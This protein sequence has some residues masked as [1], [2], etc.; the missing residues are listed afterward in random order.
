MSNK[1]YKDTLHLMTTSFSI[2]SQAQEKEPAFE[3]VWSDDSFL[4][5]YFTPPAKASF[6]LHDGPPYANGDIHIGHALNKI[7]KDIIIRIKRMAGHSVSFI[8]GWDCHGLPIE[9][10]VLKE[11]E[12]GNDVSTSKLCKVSRTYAQQWVEK[13]KKDFKR[14]GVIAE[15]NQPYVTMDPSYQSAIMESFARLVERGFITRQKKTVPWCFSCQTVLANAEIEYKERK[16][17]SCYILFPLADTQERS[18]LP[19]EILPYELSFLIWTTTPWTIPLNRAVVIHPTASYSILKLDEKRACIVGADLVDNLVKIL[20]IEKE[21]LATVPST[22][23]QSVSLQHPLIDEL[24]VPIV[25]DHG[26]GLTEGT[27]CVHSAPGCGP[28][29]YIIGIK[30]KLEIYSPLTPQGTY[31]PDIRPLHLDGLPI[32]EGQWAVLKMLKERNYLLHKT[33][34]MHSYPHCWRCHSGLM[35]RATEQWF[36]NVTHR[37]LTK[38]AR[39]SLENIQFTPSWGHRRL[40]AFLE[41]RTEWCVSRQRRWGIPIA[42]LHCTQ[43]EA[44]YTTPSFIMAVARKVAQHGVEYWHEVSIEQLLQDTNVSVEQCFGHDQISALQKETDILDVWFDAGV[45]HYAVLAKQG[46]SLPIDLYLEG[47]DQHRGWFQSALLTSLIMHDK[48]PMKHILTH[49]FVVDQH[50]H[51]MSKSKGNVV[52][53]QEVI[54]QYGAD[55]L[56]LWVAS[57]DY[58]RDITI[59]EDLIKQIAE[60]YRK[61]R[62]TCRFLLGNL[63]DFDPQGDAVPYEQLT[64]LDQAALRELEVWSGRIMELYSAYKFSAVV[65]SLAHY[66]SVR[67][68]SFYLDMVKDRLYVE[69]GQVRRSCQTVLH[70]ILSRLVRIL[71]PIMPFLAEDVYSH[72][73][74]EVSAPDSI[75]LD[76]FITSSL[77]PKADYALDE[78]FQFLQDIRSGV[79]RAI[80]EKRATGVIKHSLEARVLIFIHPEADGKRL[81]ESLLSLLSEK[82][83]SEDAFFKEWYII[84]Q[85]VRLTHLQEGMNEIGSTGFFVS[86]E[87]AHGTKCPRC[88]MWSEQT[89]TEDGL[90]DRCSTVLGIADKSS[91]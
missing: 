60:V 73:S 48:A 83:R 81:Y 40:D 14:L 10:K 32:T 28:E 30:N 74:K 85:Y 22:L 55:V 23:F 89:H 25:F 4:E 33:T 49:G 91:F 19:E 35:F 27:A 47:S 84:S 13:Q 21:V 68:S 2:R 76:K 61:I 20:G 90:C 36:C 88:W 39:A 65:Q 46:V 18:A 72:M 42:A 7:L 16:D 50:G 12:E 41:N 79:L 82:K 24:Q 56:R 57:T 64:V 11:I 63:S 1:S 29:D 37:D 80:E 53:P 69:D 67:L 43:T 34:I 75:H 70:H 78:V 5:A 51:K 77:V 87:H 66:C 59:S 45:S 86:V 71:A 58:E 38:T 52:A 17:P 31:S 62:N 26:V 15:W 3:A 6:V 54:A 8:P 44:V 9:L